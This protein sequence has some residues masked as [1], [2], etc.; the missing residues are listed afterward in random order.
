[1]LL[2]RK[3]LFIILVKGSNWLTLQ[4]KSA[5]RQEELSTRATNPLHRLLPGAP[6]VRQAIAQIQGNG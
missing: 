1:M 4:Q 6:E 2:E 3:I 5:V